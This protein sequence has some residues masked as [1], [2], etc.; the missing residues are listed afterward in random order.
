VPEI[1]P[2]LAFVL[3]RIPLPLTV[4]QIL[5][6]DLGTDLVPSLA[7]GAEP[8]EPGVMCRPPRPRDARLLDAPTFLRAYAWLG[9]IE[10]VLCLAGFFFAYWLSGWRPGMAMA[11]S[12]PLYA[13]ATTMSLAGIV[14]CQIGNLL[15]C[16]SSRESVFRL[17]WTGNRL[18]YVGI[19]CEVGLLLLLV[20]SPPLAAVFGLAP[21]GPWHWLALA[22][23]GPIVLLLEETRKLL[24]RNATPTSPAGAILRS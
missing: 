2:F 12:G 9:A 17:P 8:P 16:R 24:V 15:A 7:L 22:V 18:L 13:T 11:P 14:A 4:M 21:L 20:Y 19:A 3:L 6:V 1:V 10:A 5:A 23:F